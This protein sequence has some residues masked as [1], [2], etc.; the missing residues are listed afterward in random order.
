MAWLCL[1]TDILDCPKLAELDDATIGGWILILAAVKRHD[2]AGLVPTG[3][4]ASAL[5][6]PPRDDDPSLDMQA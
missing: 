3:Q 5:V 6:S 2:Q 4:T 1:W